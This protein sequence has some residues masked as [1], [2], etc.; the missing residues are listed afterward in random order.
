MAA[1]FVLYSA[2][3]KKKETEGMYCIVGKRLIGRR[4]HTENGKMPINYS[5]YV[6]DCDVLM[7][8]H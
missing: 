8:S 4:S 7:V 6:Y 1:K 5:L 3:T 2:E